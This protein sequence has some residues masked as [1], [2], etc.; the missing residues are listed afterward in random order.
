MKTYRIFSIVAYQDSE[1]LDYNT[2]FS[3]L[4]KLNFTYFTIKHDNDE[5]KIHYH[6]AIYTMTPTTISVI[7]KK[8]N[9]SENFIKIQDDSG[10]RYTLKKTIGYLIHYNNKDKYNYKIE[11]ITTNN[12]DLVLKYYDL[13]C[14]GN[15]ETQELKEIL[16]FLENNK[17]NCKDLLSYC[18]EN[19]FLKTF[20]KYSYYLNQ[21]VKELQYKRT[22]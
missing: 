16:L 22:Y 14:G 7:A 10:K 15:S 20:H 11:D 17:C 13:L 3:T 9:I 1:N 8:L 12:K 21:V 5:N 18:I 19:N 2:I 6:I 4:N